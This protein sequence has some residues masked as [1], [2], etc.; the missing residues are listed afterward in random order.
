ME[1]FKNGVGRPSN[2]TL[3]K[4]RNMKVL[5][6]IFVIAIVGISGYYMYNTFSTKTIESGNKNT[7]VGKVFAEINK[8]AGADYDYGFDEYSDQYHTTINAY[9]TGNFKFNVNIIKLVSQNIYYKVFTYNSDDYNKNAKIYKKC[10]MVS[11]RGETYFNISMSLTASANQKAIKVK[12]YSSKSLCDADT[13]S[14]GNTGY[15][16]GTSVA[17]FHYYDISN[18]KII[19]GDANDDGIV[20]GKDLD[21]IKK[22]ASGYSVDKINIKN[23][24]LHF[25]GKINSWDYL[26]LFR[27]VTGNLKPDLYP[28]ILFGDTNRDMV[29]DIKDVNNVKKQLEND[30]ENQSLNVD[31]DGDGRITSGDLAYIRQYLGETDIRSGYKH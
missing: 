30:A 4:R 27:Y 12:I 31:F 29:L 19:F 5:I 7:A 22:Y 13:S 8:P 15:S 11:T 17:V 3:K 25:D 28:L 6:A 2:E 16:E 14:N 10:T 21:L 24:D 1:L 20:N 26:V 23:S 18:K 9:K